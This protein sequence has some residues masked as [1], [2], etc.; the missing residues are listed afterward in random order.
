MNSD[1]REEDDLEFHQEL[2]SSDESLEDHQGNGHSLEDSAASKEDQ[3]T[4][5]PTA[6]KK[7][8]LTAKQ[9]AKLDPST[10][11]KKC[12]QCGKPSD[13]LIRCRKD[14][15][16]KWFLLCPGTCWKEASGG[17]VDGT[18][19]TPWYRYGGVWKNK[20]AAT[21]GKKPKHTDPP[22]TVSKPILP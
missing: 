8:P 4:E 21:S 18:K 10:S 11:T 2:E 16:E 17:K 20:K 3:S 7:K 22:A 19:D 6:S 5:N 15:T 13:V 1:A 12:E 9:A 14:E